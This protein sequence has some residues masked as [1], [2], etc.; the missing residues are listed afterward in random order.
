MRWLLL[1]SFFRV[2][3]SL[4]FP[5]EVHN[6]QC[7]FRAYK[8]VDTKRAAHKKVDYKTKYFSLTP[9][10]GCAHKETKCIISDGK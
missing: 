5:V 4:L 9:R 10:F 1:E 6:L 8:K 3:L 7:F 2:F